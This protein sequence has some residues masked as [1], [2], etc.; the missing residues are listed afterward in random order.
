ML[1]RI[2]TTVSHLS[3]IL[4][5]IGFM[6]LL[7]LT[8]MTSV[9]ILLRWLAAYPLQGVNDV[10]AIVIALVIAA[11]LPANLARKQNITVEIL[12]S[13][14]GRRA[15]AALDA[16]GGLFTLTFVMLLAWRFGIYAREITA[17]GQTT[18]VLKIPVGPGWWLVTIFMA[19]A[20]PIQLIVVLR[21]FQIAIT[22]DKPTD[23]SPET[24]L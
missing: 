14:L 12:G 18:W 1:K 7:I 2:S 6:G 19:C 10:T 5:L 20:I 17:S 11:C 22:G 3:E 23:N 16:I 4:A 8:I 13:V 9:D 15:K 21:D 24:V